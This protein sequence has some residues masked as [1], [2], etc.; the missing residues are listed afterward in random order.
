L[1]VF[2]AAVKTRPRYAILASMPRR[3]GIVSLLLLLAALSSPTAGVARPL[4]SMRLVVSI[5]WLDKVP[6]RGER[7]PAHPNPSHPPPAAVTAFPSTE[8]R[9]STALP[10]WHFQLPPPAILPAL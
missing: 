1:P 5:A 3:P 9:P 7:R 8:P 10:L 2:G 6:A 4:E